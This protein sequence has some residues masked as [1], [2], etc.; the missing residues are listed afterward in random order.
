MTRRTRPYYAAPRAGWVVERTF[1]WMANFRRLKQDYE[2]LA[3]TLRAL[4]IS[5][6]AMTLLTRATRDQ[7]R[8]TRRSVRAAARA[9]ARRPS[10]LY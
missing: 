3:E 7:R 10:G 4:H 8:G 6:H 1:A 2:R 9:S 5:A